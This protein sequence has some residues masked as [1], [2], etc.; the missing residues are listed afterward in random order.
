MILYPPPCCQQIANPNPHKTSTV[1]TF[2]TLAKRTLE[3]GDDRISIRG[4]A[5]GSPM[6]KKLP[7]IDMNIGQMSHFGY[8]YFPPK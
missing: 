5:D 7:H 3:S 8:C 6:Y 1:V 4:E 2:H